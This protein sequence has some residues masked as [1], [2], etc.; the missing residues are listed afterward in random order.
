MS[1]AERDFF[2]PDSI[3]SQVKTMLNT[4]SDWSLRVE[5][6]TGSTPEDTIENR[7]SEDGTPIQYIG[8]SRPRVICT[9]G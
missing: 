1:T 2:G 8:E 3:T 7:R 5:R 9:N 4:L 6:I